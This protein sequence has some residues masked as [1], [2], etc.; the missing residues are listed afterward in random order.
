MGGKDGYRVNLGRV[1]GLDIFTLG[2]GRIDGRSVPRV[3][4]RANINP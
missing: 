1:E 3:Q 4:R 2:I